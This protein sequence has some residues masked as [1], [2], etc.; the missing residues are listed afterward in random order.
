MMHTESDRKTGFTLVEL[1]VVIAIIGI[2]VAMLLPAVQAAREAARRTQCMNNFKQIGLAFHNYHD[3]MLSFPLGEL[4]IH[5]TSCYSG[6]DMAE[7]YAKGW[8]VRILPY[9][10]LVELGKSYDVEFD[11]WG[12]YGPYQIDLGLTRI[13]T[14]QCPSDGQDELIGVGSN[15]NVYTNHPNG[16]YFYETNVGGVAD[17]KS[18][19]KAGAHNFR[20]CPI[21]DG[22]GM[23]LNLT[24]V[25]IRDVVDGTSKTLLVGE[26]TGGES[27]SKQGFQWVHINIFTTL[28]G[29]NGPDS[30]PGGAA[31]TNTG[32]NGFSSYHP[33]G[34]HFARADGSVH[35]ESQDIDAL[36]LKAL[37]TRAGQDSIE[38]EP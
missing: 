13:E 29:I 7:Y 36:I 30:I 27:G 32:N 21:I 14:F 18:S 5:S 24:R 2:L 6:P 8:G 17:S 23:L 11:F 35:F 22:D 20:Q 10:E 9:L 33:G 12:I 34:C 25:R 26:L 19:W 1:L 3:A 31:F 15:G 38:V 16:I 37:T 28:L 4:Y